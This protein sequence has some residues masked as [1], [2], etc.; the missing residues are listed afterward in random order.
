[1]LLAVTVAHLETNERRNNNRQ[2]LSQGHVKPSHCNLSGNCVQMKN[3][4]DTQD[5][6]HSEKQNCGYSMSY[7]INS[8]PFSPPAQIV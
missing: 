4:L 3:Y 6:E 8:N 2:T 7:S 5:L 1:M